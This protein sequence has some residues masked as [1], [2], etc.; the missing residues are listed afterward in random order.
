V[1]LALV[2]GVTACGTRVSRIDEADAGT[3]VGTMSWTTFH[4]DP[5]RRGWNPNESV[6][7]PQNVSSPG[8]GL[9]WESA[10]FDAYQGVP[11]RMY[12]SPLYLDAL[13]LGPGPFA[14]STLP[15]IFGATTNAD[16]YAITAFSV[17]ATPA[18]TILWKTRVGTPAGIV[19][20]LPIGILSTPVLDTAHTPPRLYVTAD[21]VDAS[22]QRAWRVFA[23]DASTGSVLPGW[24]VEMSAA[25]LSAVNQNGPALFATPATQ[26]QRGALN[27]SPD[28][29]LLY[30]PFGGYFDTAPGWLAVVD[31]TTAQVVSAF[32]GAPETMP[33]ANAGMW[34]ASGVSVANDGSVYVVTGNSPAGPLPHT[35]GESVL[36]WGPG[37]PLKL[38]GTY[39]VWNHCQ[40]DVGDTDL[41]GGGVVLLPER[42]GTTIPNLA[43]TGG[44][45]GNAYLLD[46]DAMPG[47]LDVRPSC[48]FHSPVD[49]PRD[50]SLWDPS[51]PR[52]YYGG[53]PG[54]LNVFAPYTD[55]DTQL[56]AKARSTP[57]YF[58]GPDGTD[59]LVYAGTTRDVATNLVAQPPGVARLKV[60]SAAAGVPF[61]QVDGMEP[62]LVFQNP[63]SPVISSNGSSNAVAWIL[64]TNVNRLAS[65]LTA[66]PATLY[67]VDVMGLR[68]L[69]ASQPADLHPGGKYSHP[70]VARGVVF[71]GTDRISAFGLAHNDR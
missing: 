11:G 41:C 60:A 18:G 51:A 31:T 71:V 21:T 35:W 44:K 20:G 55:Q 53:K 17:G 1:C 8:F 4:G 25:A 39:T 69:Y 67:A 68:A 66:P 50:L 5:A 48:N 19:D 15:V 47:Q 23:L 9:R 63:G 54:P 24:P 64:D 56:Q 46:A 42:K 7:S 3:T 27:L 16:V 58:R 38:T 28:G 14:G 29:S 30:V 2:C 32:S 33:Q 6:L 37:V 45:Q 26:S 43:A 22:F 40:L 13:T 59:Y 61:L 65:M 34:A 10:P 70:V 62:T 52:A 36:R 57:A 12:A 49:G